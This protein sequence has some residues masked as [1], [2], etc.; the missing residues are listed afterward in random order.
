MPGR[1]A[2]VGQPVT[3]VGGFR[4][5]MRIT[6]VFIIDP[7]LI[8]HLFLIDPNRPRDNSNTPTPTY[9]HTCVAGETSVG[10][11][12]PDAGCSRSKLAKFTCGG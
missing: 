2:L 12:A 6:D 4:P 9:S 8:D 10:I 1:Q 11:N 3:Q 7:T 5:D